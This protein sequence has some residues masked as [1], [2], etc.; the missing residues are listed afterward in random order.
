[1][2]LHGPQWVNREP[3]YCFMVEINWGCGT[4]ICPLT[5]G[6]SCRN[7]ATIAVFY[8]LPVIQLVITYQTVSG[9]LSW[10]SF[11]VLL[12]ATW[13][14]RCYVVPESLVYPFALVWAGKVGFCPSPALST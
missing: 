11:H 4:H 7:I 5:S 3:T 2:D 1:M 13:P 9:F 12:I 6:V 14:P 10:A 8:A